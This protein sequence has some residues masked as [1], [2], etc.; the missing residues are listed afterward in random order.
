ML[1]RAS[2]DVW[3]KYMIK[4]S[5]FVTVGFALSFSLF[6]IL[7]N[8]ALLE[9]Q[10]N[11]DFNATV[12]TALKNQSYSFQFPLNGISRKIFI[13]YDQ[14]FY[15]LLQFSNDLSEFLDKKSE[16]RFIREKE[17]HGN[18]IGQYGVSSIVSQQTIFTFDL[19]L[20]DDEP[21]N[22]DPSLYWD[23]NKNQYKRSI[24]LAV[25]SLLR[26]TS[27][28]DPS[29][30][31]RTTTQEKLNLLRNHFAGTSWAEIPD[32]VFVE[33]IEQNKL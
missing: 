7:G 5:L 28:R 11:P 15:R 21:L 10:H 23:S 2:K 3:V 17:D 27:S 19:T 22:D 12:V 29:P 26:Q 9:L 32:F 16:I 8:A 6:P 24:Q 33:I 31:L 25:I 18:T 30:S 1:I 14:S 13:N 4:K 20:L